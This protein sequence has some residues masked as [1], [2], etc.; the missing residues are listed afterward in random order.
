MKRAT[1]ILGKQYILIE[2]LS[3][4]PASVELHYIVVF[5]G[6]VHVFSSS[7]IPKMYVPHCLFLCEI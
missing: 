4:L 3:I 7:E 2:F 6:G 5:G 1:G